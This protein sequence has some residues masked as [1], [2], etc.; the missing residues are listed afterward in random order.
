MRFGGSVGTDND[1]ENFE[2][3]KIIVTCGPSFEP[4]DGVRRLTNFSTGELGVLLCEA[5]LRQG[6][7]VHCLKGSGATYAG[8]EGCEVTR[9]GTNEE[10]LWSLRES[11][12]GAG[13]GAVFHAAA[14][15]DY[16]VARVRDAEGVER[17]E[18]KIPTRSGSL[19]LE[20]EP[21]IKVISDLRSL[22]PSA[23]I[24]GWKYELTGTRE[25]AIGKAQRQ[26]VEART[27]ACV[28]N[29]AA[30]GVGYGLCDAAGLRGSVSRKED[31]GELLGSWLSSRG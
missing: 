19:T 30:F 13:V 26:I 4:I 14:L 12:S 18:A 3:M 2:G 22:F 17:T 23:L 6:H 24:V 25:E 15:C 10:L 7:Q 9:F 20:L 31:L 16:R 11:A 28:V 1:V 5:F 27:D 29:G 21:T 8:P